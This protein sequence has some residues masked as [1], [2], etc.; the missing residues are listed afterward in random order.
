MQ[1]LRWFTRNWADTASPGDPALVPPE[2][3]L[4]P[5]EVLRRLEA[6]ISQ[7][8]LWRIE[9]I[10]AG[11]NEMKLTRSTRLLRFID[12]VTLRLEPLP[13]GTRIHAHSQSRIGAA[14]LGQNRR[15]LLEL[16][17]ALRRV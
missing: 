9:T 2:L 4:P 16:F 17:A 3:S 8:P 10:N 14:D 5:P 11:R 13:T 7:L 6:V 12:D 1:L 15:N